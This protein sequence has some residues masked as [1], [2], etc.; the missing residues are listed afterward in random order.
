[1]RNFKK[2]QATP[3]GDTPIGTQY[4]VGRGVDDNN[5]NNSNNNNNNNNNFY[6][7]K[8]TFRHIK[9]N[10]KTVSNLFTNGLQNKITIVNA[11]TMDSI[12]V[13][14]NFFKV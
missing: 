9:F 4:S 11:H 6:F 13:N 12:L 3:L 5:N 8:V 2:A 7:L 14:M 1:V 10:N